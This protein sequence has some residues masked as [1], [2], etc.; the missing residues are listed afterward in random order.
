MSVLPTAI[1]PSIDVSRFD[2]LTTEGS[3]SS[4]TLLTSY[5]DA[6]R[7]VG[8]LTVGAS[9]ELEALLKELIAVH[10]PIDALERKLVG[11][12]SQ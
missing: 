8:A 1:A 9:D 11:G 3:L 5:G 10:A 12:R 2:Q 6:G 4:G 7:L